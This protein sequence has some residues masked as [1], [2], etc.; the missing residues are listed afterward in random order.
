MT[1]TLQ[2]FLSGYDRK[3]T[4]QAY[5]SY[6]IKFLSFIYSY[7]REN[8]KNPIS[9]QEMVIFE[10]FALQYITEKRDYE[11]DLINFVKVFDGKTTSMVTYTSVI[12]EFLRQNNI[13]VENSKTIKRKMPKRFS[14]SKRADLN[15]ALIRTLLSHSDE[16]VKAILLIAIS[17]GMRISEI[18]NLTEKNIVPVKDQD[19]FKIIIEGDEQEKTGHEKITFITPEAGRAIA[20]WKKVRAQYFNN[21]KFIG[22]NLN[23]NDNGLIFPF[24]DSSFNQ[25]FVAVLKK[26]GLYEQDE[27]TGRSSIT[28][29]HMRSF[30]RTVLISSGVPEAIAEHLIHSSSKAYNQYTETQ[31][32]E[33][34]LRGVEA[35]STETDPILKK[36]YSEAIDRVNQLSNDQ[37]NQ[38]QNLSTVIQQLADYQKQ[39]KIMQDKMAALEQNVHGWQELVNDVATG[40]TKLRADDKTIFVD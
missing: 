20:E 24:S 19:I 16:K 37:I 31:L 5:K 1:N 29:H 10:A 34:Y 30:F 32:V 8:S 4:A 13:K 27:K 36:K 18:L 3:S 35:L 15:I 9:E 23:K 28:I 22:A 39:V 17:S 12:R 11:Q 7:T 40:K 2:K 25:M 38:T 21:K 14:K 26:S 33:A 6:V